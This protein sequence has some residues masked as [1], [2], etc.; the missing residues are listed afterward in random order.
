MK[1]K[2]EKE[3]NERR[4]ILI[5]N[6]LFTLAYF[7]V[8]EFAP[9]SFELWLH[10]FDLEGAGKRIS[11]LELEKIL[12]KEKQEGKIASRNGFWFFNEFEKIAKDRIKKQKISVEKIKKVRRMALFFGCV[13]YLR[14]VFVTGT[15][16]MKNSQKASDWDVLVVTKEERIWLGRLFFSLF[17]EILKKRRKK[18]KIKDRFCLNHFLTL[19][20]LEL[21]EKSEFSANEVSFSF[22]LFGDDV[23]QKF[24][25]A[26]EGWIKKKKPNFS[27]NFIPSPFFRHSFLDKSKIIGRSIECLFEFLGL[28]K[29]LNKKLKNPMTQKILNNPKTYL[30][31]AD[32]RFG[33][34]CLV[35]L[36]EPHRKKVKKR[37][38]EILEKE[39][40]IKN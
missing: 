31:G 3:N 28:G 11:F 12:V 8:L 39:G 19:D 18:G 5:K 16:A 40:I 1:K 35:F 6:V 26:N 14:G 27:A 9:T 21:E 4:V 13:P 22:P 34:S 23:F 2:S 32:I 29:F 20:N 7:N 33:D 24:L 15:L 25:V 30:D 38:L 17:L 10:Y 37:S 36:P